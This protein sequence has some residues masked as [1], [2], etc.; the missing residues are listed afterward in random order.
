[1]FNC[2]NLN[3]YNLPY[4]ILFTLS[5]VLIVQIVRLWYLSTILIS[6]T[7]PNYWLSLDLLQS[8]FESIHVAISKLKSLLKN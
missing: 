8:Q 3:S 4:V 7:A 1:M 2:P 5:V 6:Y